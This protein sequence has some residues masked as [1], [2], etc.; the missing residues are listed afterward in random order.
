MSPEIRAL[1]EDLAAIFKTADDMGQLD[2]ADF[3]DN[4]GTIFRLVMRARDILKTSS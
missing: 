4:A 1:I 3:V 2:A